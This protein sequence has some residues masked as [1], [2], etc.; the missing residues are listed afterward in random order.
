MNLSDLYQASVGESDRKFEVLRSDGAES[1]HHITLI[2]PA[3]DKA[4]KAVFM[5]GAAEREKLEKFK[6]DNAELE[7]DCKEIGNYTAFNLNFEA[8]CQDLRDAFC[9]EI[10]EGWGF[11]NEFSRDELL[12]A[13]KNYRAPYLLSLQRQII[14]AFTDASNAHAKK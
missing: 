3:S 5:L 8:C 4:A 2:D 11:E 6:A 10:V 14:T 9:L 7:S 1:G 12:K 13:I